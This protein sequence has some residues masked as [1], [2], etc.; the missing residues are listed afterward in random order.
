MVGPSKDIRPSERS[1]TAAVYASGDT[2]PV[3]SGVLI[4]RRRVLTCRHVVKDLNSNGLSVAFPAAVDDPFRDPIRVDRVDLATHERADVAL[5][6]LAADA[7]ADVAPAPLRRPRANDL[8]GAPG[9]PTG[10][11]TTPAFPRTVWLVKT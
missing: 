11:A 1:W 5:L 6:T 3:G 4:D 8:V 10:S 7:P 2:K 9:G